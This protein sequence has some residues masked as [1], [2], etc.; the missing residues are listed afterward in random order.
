M[1][2]LTILKFYRSKT[3]FHYVVILRANLKSSFITRLL[4]ER[5]MIKIDEF[6][7]SLR[8]RKVNILI[9]TKTLNK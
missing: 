8:A 7:Y 6:D 4:Q 9:Y 5:L 1:G 3:Q 2:F